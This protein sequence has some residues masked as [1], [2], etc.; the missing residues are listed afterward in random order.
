MVR[1]FMVPK[2]LLILVCPE[3]LCPLLDFRLPALGALGET[4]L[5]MEARYHGGYRVW[6]HRSVTEV[7]GD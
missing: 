1:S 2:I 7:P 4:A 5:S 3:V 6:R